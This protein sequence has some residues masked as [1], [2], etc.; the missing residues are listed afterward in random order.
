VHRPT[1]TAIRPIRAKP[2]ESNAERPG[3]KTIVSLLKAIRFATASVILTIVCAECPVPFMWRFT[4]QPDRR[5]V[6]QVWVSGSCCFSGSC[7]ALDYREYGRKTRPRSRRP[8]ILP[9]NI[10][11]CG[12]LRD[13]IFPIPASSPRRE[14]AASDR[15]AVSGSV[16]TWILGQSRRG[17]PSGA[18][19][20]CRVCQAR[21]RRRTSPSAGVFRKRTPSVGRAYGGSR[22]PASPPSTPPRWC[23]V[24]PGACIPFFLVKK[25]DDS[26]E[27]T[28]SFLS[29]PPI[30][31]RASAK[32]SSGDAE[33][34]ISE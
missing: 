19:A 14:Q 21:G 25:P 15:S 7:F 5:A 16:S 9:A 23:P 8:C 29:L 28:V 1:A 32:R 10:I 27:S 20:D 34:M 3:R 33:R 17:R 12:T 6:S 26:P 31:N 22:R 30:A 13:M 24:V 18:Q 4:R 11:R 2:P